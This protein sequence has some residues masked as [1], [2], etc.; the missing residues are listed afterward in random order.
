MYDALSWAVLPVSQ[1]EE[2]HNMIVDQKIKAD[3]ASDE[4]N[5]QTMQLDNLTTETL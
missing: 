2:G 3:G 1:F 4:T 5:K